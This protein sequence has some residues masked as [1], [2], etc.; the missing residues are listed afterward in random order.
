M[1]WCPVVKNRF[2]DFEN[3]RLEIPHIN[4]ILSNLRAIDQ[5]L[6][7]AMKRLG[8]RYRWSR[9]EVYDNIHSLPLI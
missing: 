1:Y 3:R 2:A 9:Q 4:A 7:R 5:A 6:S 8:D